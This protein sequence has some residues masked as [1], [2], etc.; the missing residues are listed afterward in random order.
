M[1]IRA[2]EAVEGCAGLSLIAGPVGSEDIVHVPGTPWLIASGLNLGAPAQFSL[3]DT[4]TKTAVPL[5]LSCQPGGAEGDQGATP[6]ELSS[7]STDGLALREGSGGGPVL[8][9]ANHGDR[10]AIEIFAID[11]AEARPALR[12]I[13]CARLPPNALPNAVRPLPDG[14]VLVICP[15]DPTDRDCWSRMARGENT[16]R[17]LRWHAGRGVEEL[18]NG[19]MSGGN[20][21]EVSTDGSLVYASAWSARELVVLSLRD[22]QRRAIALDF[23]PDNIHALADGTLLVAGQRTT[24]EAIAACTGASCPQPWVVARI[25]PESGEVRELLSGEG[26]AKVNYA[27]G[28]LVVGDTMYVTVRGD[29]CIV[30]KAIDE[31]PSM[32]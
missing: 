19:A 30:Y 13:G 25:D 3:I 22:G 4:R 9:A 12:W 23:L 6:P 8:F 11:S 28:A 14:T 5:A 10:L 31:L 26:S 1:A 20:G 27:C 24:V 18:P 2:A 17:I 15:Y 29:R 21:L 32:G 16:G 7:M